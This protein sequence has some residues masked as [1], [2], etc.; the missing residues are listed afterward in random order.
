MKDIRF[1]PKNNSG[2]ARVGKLIVGNKEVN[3]P[4]IFFGYRIGDR[5][6]VWKDVNVEALMPNAYD[7]YVGKKG[8]EKVLNGGIHSFLKFD[9][10]I[11]MDSGGFYFQKKG[12]MNVSAQEILE[13]EEKSKPDIGVVL[14]FPLDPKNLSVTK[15]R[16]RRTM[17]NTKFMLKNSSIPLI[18]VLHGYDKE[19]LKYAASFLESDPS[20]IALGS[21][22]ALLYPF[23]VNIIK[24][25]VN[26]VLT[27]RQMFPKT[28][29][30]VFGLGS[31]RLAP[32]M[33][34][35]GVDSVDAK[36]WVWKAVRHM[37]YLNG[38]IV[39]LKEDTWSWTPIY[40]GKNHICSCPVCSKYGFNGLLGK[41]AWQR[42]AIHNVWNYQ[43][44]VRRIRRHIEEG[45]FEKYLEM[46]FKGTPFY[47]SYKYTQKMKT[48][49]IRID[50][51]FL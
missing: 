2:T 48:K 34:Y 3:T 23:R 9:G 40:K 22:A 35:L 43:M 39:C 27:V 33:F 16:I 28:F 6:H 14:D 45:T 50:N 15:K 49:K 21:Q 10:L 1:E 25:I 32:L 17:E 37:I 8:S 20:M 29:L 24:K 7:I 19:S 47:L 44:D 30:H 4:L 38:R 5:P 26:T 36:T 42:R 12:K 13:I 11:M 31:P 18:V 51:W 46:R 41:H